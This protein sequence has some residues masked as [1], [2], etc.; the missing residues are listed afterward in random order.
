MPLMNMFA[1]NTNIIHNTN[2]HP[3]ASC[4][5][6]FRLKIYTPISNNGAPHLTLRTTLFPLGG[7]EWVDDLGAILPGA[8]MQNS[9]RNQRGSQSSI[10]DIL[11]LN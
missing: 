11:M 6:F 3:A 7:F 1:H 10:I 4:E 2:S 9:S 8:K 5:E